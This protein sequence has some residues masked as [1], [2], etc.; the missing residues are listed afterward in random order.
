MTKSTGKAN[1]HGL[2]K[3]PEYRV[4]KNMVQRCCN[5]NNERYIDY[6]GRGITICKEWR[7]SFPAFLLHIGPRPSP[8]HSLDRIDNE[9]GYEP[10]NVRWVTVHEQNR[11]QRSNLWFTA[12]GETHTLSDWARIKQIPINTLYSRAISLSWSFEDALA[13]ITK[14]LNR[15]QKKSDW[16]RRTVRSMAA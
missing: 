1:R 10:G 8:I 15:P 6:G 12:Y 5:P 2:S 4:W 14:R 16:K 7:K 11:N 3:R 13:G 9:R